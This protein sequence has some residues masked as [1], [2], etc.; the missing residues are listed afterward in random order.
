MLSEIPVDTP[1]ENLEVRHGGYPVASIAADRNVA[2]P[3]DRLHGVV[4][5]GRIGELAPTAFSF[6]GATA[7]GRLRKEELPGWIDRF[8]EHDIDVLLLV[9]V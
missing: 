4:D 5:F 3:L 8:R 6:V 1:P 7:Q 9:P 2:F